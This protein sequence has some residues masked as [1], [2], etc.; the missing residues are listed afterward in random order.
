M[1]VHSSLFLLFAAMLACSSDD[2]RTDSGTDGGADVEAGPPARPAVPQVQNQKGAVLAAP[3]V[4]P[5]F[6]GSD[7][8][9]PQ[10][11][12]FLQKLASSTY[13]TATTSE[14]G[15]GAM[16]VAPSIVVT[17]PAPATIDTIGIESFLATY[18]DN[19]PNDVFAIFYPSSTTIISKLS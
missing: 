18:V 4:V 7:A 2:T 11:E 13:W 16:T 1:L 8:F 10:V 19:T 5:I 14:Y 17:D 9:Q 3:R 6:F 15:I 12:D